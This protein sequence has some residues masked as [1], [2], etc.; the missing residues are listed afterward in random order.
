MRKVIQL[1]VT[2]TAEYADGI[3]KPA[4]FGKPSISSEN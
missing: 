2:S 1:P 4:Q 3:A